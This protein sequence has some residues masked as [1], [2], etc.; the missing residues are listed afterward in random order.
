[1][2]PHSG[3]QAL[4]GSP[5][6]RARLAEPL[7]DATPRRWLLT[8]VLTSSLGRAFKFPRSTGE[9]GTRKVERTALEVERMALQ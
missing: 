7:K 9:Q 1:M 6:K 2:W 3:D 8:N 5:R 4:G